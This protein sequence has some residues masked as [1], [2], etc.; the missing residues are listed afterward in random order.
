MPPAHRP[1]LGREYRRGFM[2]G[3][4]SAGCCTRLTIESTP[5]HDRLL[6]DGTPL[7]KQNGMPFTLPLSPDTIR[8][9]QAAIVGQRTLG[10]EL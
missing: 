9:R 2:L 4:P 1:R 10:I 7:R 8:W 6:R 3:W 5:R